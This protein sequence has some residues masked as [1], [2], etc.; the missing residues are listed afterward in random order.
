MSQLLSDREDYIAAFS[1]FVSASPSSY[2]AAHAV[3]EALEGAGFEAHDERDAWAPITA[4]SCG[5]VVRDGAV[6]AWRAGDGV[7]A[8]SPVR[9]LGAHTDSPGFML[10]PQPDFVAEGWT[11]LGVEVY[12]GPLLNSWLDRDL[13]IAGRLITRDGNEHLASTGPVAR[14]PQLAIHLDRDVGEGLK[15]DRQRHT[16]PVLGVGAGVSALGLLADAAGV[17]LDEIVG[18]DA[19]LF[20]TQAPA[21]IGATGELFA[22]PQLDNLTSVFAGLV[23]LLEREPAPGTIAMLAAFDHEEHGHRH[24]Q[25]GPFYQ[26]PIQGIRSMD[27]G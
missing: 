3:A 17:A 19:R 18:S 7:D 25:P 24:L 4:G 2:H 23:A 5:F 16:Q 22:S 26:G 21:R 15:L 27:K 20:D 8:L 12:G 1:D 11:Q 6:I 13:G 10:K 14:I 9:M